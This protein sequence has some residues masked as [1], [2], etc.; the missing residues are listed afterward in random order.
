MD[1]NCSILHFVFFQ[2]RED[3]AKDS[4]ARRSDLG[5]VRLYDRRYASCGCEPHRSDG[6]D[7]LLVQCSTGGNN[8]TVRGTPC[9]P[10]PY[11]RARL[12]GRTGP[13]TPTVLAAAGGSMEAA[14]TTPIAPPCWLHSPRLRRTPSFIAIAC[15]W[16]ITRVRIPTRRCRRH[17]SCRR[18]RFSAVGT[19]TAWKVILRHELQD[20]LGIAAVVLLPAH[21]L[22][23]NL[24]RITQPLLKVQLGLTSTR[25]NVNARWPP[26]PRVR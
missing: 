4:G 17:R 18:S 24:R 20:V 13:A 22:G 23:P 9:I 8:Q 2:G 11:H 6:S 5:G 12:A 15:N 10:V 3:T 19:Q 25:T 1:R 26:S 7:L 21:L 16:F 14:T